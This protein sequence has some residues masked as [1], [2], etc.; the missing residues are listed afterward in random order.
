M[1]VSGR[2]RLRIRMGSRAIAVLGVLKPSRLQALEALAALSN[3]SK[4][5]RYHESK[6]AREQEQ[7]TVIAR[8]REKESKQPR[9]QAS[10][11]ASKQRRETVLI[12]CGST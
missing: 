10:K 8:A 4:R 7:E 5:V 1:A 3:K 11:Q 2:E 12:P 9:D 6:R